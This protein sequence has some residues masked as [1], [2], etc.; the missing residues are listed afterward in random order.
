MCFVNYILKLL[1]KERKKGSEEGGRRGRKA[2]KEGRG[3]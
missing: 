1:E 2:G 3:R